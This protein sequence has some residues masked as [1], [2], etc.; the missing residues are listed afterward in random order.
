MNMNNITIFL[1]FFL[2]FSV[3]STN[4]S[5]QDIF[6]TR[7]AHIHVKSKNSVKNVEADNYQMRGQIDP[8][9]GKVEFVGLLKS[10]EF[11]L[12]ALDQAFNHDKVNLTQYPRI[13]YDGKIKNLKS[14]NFSK[15]GTYDVHIKGTLF[16]WDEK[17][18]TSAKGK[19]IVNTDGT[20][21]AESIF[22]ITIEEK[23][24]NK[25]N[26]LIKEKLPSVMS[27]D[28]NTFG[29]SRNINISLEGNFKKKF[30]F[31]N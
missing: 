8:I 19:L 25:L 15:P 5:A 3:L 13:T 17:R 9:T 10:F 16:I 26:S 2:C 21:R 7:T 4:V 27:L 28:A 18:V 29:V 6:V 31:R 1:S 11:K 12:G 22:D 14:I 24:M 20:I 30:V 23:N